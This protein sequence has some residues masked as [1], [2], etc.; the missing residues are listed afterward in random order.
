MARILLADDDRLLANM[1]QY[2][3]RQH[4]YEVH[5]VQDG[6]EAL[7]LLVAEDWDLL[8]MDVM[9]PVYD[10]F[11]VLRRLR[12]QGIELPVVMITARIRERDVERARN[13]GAS[14]YMPKPLHMEEVLNTVQQL[15][16]DR[17]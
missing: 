12:Q 3:L 9:M 14:A 1:L 6:A 13:L 7:E 5:W 17:A 2:Q 15:V 10:G 4:S 8:L 16:E 11:Q